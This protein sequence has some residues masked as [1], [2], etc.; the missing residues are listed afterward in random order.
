LGSAEA[1]EIEWYLYFHH[2]N[3]A[4]KYLQIQ[5]AQKNRGG[6][7][8]RKKDTSDAVVSESN[9]LDQAK[10]EEGMQYQST[11]GIGTRLTV[12]FI[13][14]M[15]YQVLILQQLLQMAVM[16]ILKKV[17]QQTNSFHHQ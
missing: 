17:A 3:F 5:L 7:K 16:L 10:K 6:S 13:Q 12:I 15:L 2:F 1:K 9:N 11:I 4:A 14:V 8:R